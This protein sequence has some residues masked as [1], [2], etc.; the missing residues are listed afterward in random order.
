[1]EI[2]AQQGG[3]RYDQLGT[4]FAFWLEWQEI[5]EGKPRRII[6]TEDVQ[7]TLASLVP[8]TH[9]AGTHTPIHRWSRLSF[10]LRCGER[11]DL[12]RWKGRNRCLQ[13]LCSP[14]SK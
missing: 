12:T 3:M 5:E 11:G 2:V 6:T 9:N 13:G 1:M 8:L 10:P 7:E 14:L 4:W